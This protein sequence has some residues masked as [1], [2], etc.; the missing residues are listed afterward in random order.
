MY[1]GMYL[2]HGAE[3]REYPYKPHTAYTVWGVTI[4]GTEYKSARQMCCWGNGVH[5]CASLPVSN[6]PPFP[7]PLQLCQPHGPPAVA[8]QHT[9]R[10]RGGR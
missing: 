6:L 9:R 4:Y 2:W 5:V 10:S 7:C 1:R 3:G 8:T